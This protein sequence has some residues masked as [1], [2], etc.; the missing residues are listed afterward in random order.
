MGDWDERKKGNK[1]YEVYIYI[2]IYISNMKR[3]YQWLSRRNRV[4]K[5]FKIVLP[6][7]SSYFLCFSQ[8]ALNLILFPS[9]CLNF[10]FLRIFFPSSS[11]SNCLFFF[12][13]FFPSRF[14]NQLLL[15]LLIT[16][17]YFSLFNSYSLLHFLFIFLLLQLLLQIIITNTFYHSLINSW[18][19]SLSSSLSLSSSTYHDNS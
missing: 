5:E 10:S 1:E 18:F 9:F 8:K 2:Y 12:H 11:F 14:F 3:I 19:Y 4:H 17:I 16:I 7:F 13:M 6:V 15:L